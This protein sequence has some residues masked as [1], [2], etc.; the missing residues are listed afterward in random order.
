MSLRILRLHSDFLEIIWRLTNLMW[1]IC[2]I[3]IGLS[4]VCLVLEMRTGLTFASVALV[5]YSAFVLVG[6]ATWCIVASHFEDNVFI[7]RR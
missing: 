5:C 6:L 3:L 1:S 4:A 2:Y 7:I